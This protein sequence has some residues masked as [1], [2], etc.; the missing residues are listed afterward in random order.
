MNILKFKLTILISCILGT[1]GLTLLYTGCQSCLRWWENI[2]L[3]S[4]GLVVTA[5]GIKMVKHAFE[6]KF[7]RENVLND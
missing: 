7:W 4:L 2:I 3:L 1:T 6:I 5:G